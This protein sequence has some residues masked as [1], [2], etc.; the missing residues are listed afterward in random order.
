MSP[1][2]PGLE[3]RELLNSECPAQSTCIEGGESEDAESEVRVLVGWR[4]FLLGRP[5]VHLHY[6]QGGRTAKKAIT[7]KNR[8]KRI[9]RAQESCWGARGPDCGTWHLDGVW[10]Y[11]EGLNKMLVSW[12][13]EKVLIDR[14]NSIRKKIQ[15]QD[16]EEWA[17]GWKSFS[18][19]GLQ[20][21]Q[22][23][24]TGE[25]WKRWFRVRSWK[26]L[27]AIKGGFFNRQLWLLKNK[28]Q[29]AECKFP[30]CFLSH[31]TL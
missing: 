23:D 24:G 12:E 11:I 17:E 30:N 7:V 6:I 14:R 31:C 9:I 10:I 4:G 3:T 26:A 29:N 1:P 28:H 16:I 20:K 8:G 19:I 5:M 2:E 13:R 25:N 22:G 18:M 21:A 27:N 15:R